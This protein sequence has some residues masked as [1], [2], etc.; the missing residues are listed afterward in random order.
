M[1]VFLAVFLVH[2]FYG[3]TESIED[4]YWRDFKG[5]VPSD[6]IP[7]VLDSDETSY[8]GQFS[9]VAEYNKDVADIHTLV[10]TLYTGNRRAVAAYNG[11]TVYSSDHS[12]LKILCSSNAR[13]R[14][15][16]KSIKSVFSPNCRFVIAGYEDNVPMYVGRAVRGKDKVL[17]KVYSDTS[18]HDAK[19]SVPHQGGEEKYDAYELLTYCY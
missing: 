8:I 1:K 19:L 11:R 3:T 16:W 2:W 14:Y 10:A 18:F 13:Y 4:Y 5:L 15:S 6:A 12:N 7:C 17:G 9:V